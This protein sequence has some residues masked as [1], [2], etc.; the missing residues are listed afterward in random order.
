MDELKAKIFWQL[1][2]KCSNKVL[3]RIQ[4][5]F[6]FLP[7]PSALSSDQRS[8]LPESLLRILDSHLQQNAG[9]FV[10][11]LEYAYEYTRSQNLRLIELGGPD[12]PALLAQI[13]DAPALFYLLGS[14]ELV[15]Q[16][17]I[18]IVGSRRCSRGGQV[19]ARI[20]SRHLAEAGFTITSGLA[21]GI[22]TAAHQGALEVAMQN[23][24][25]ESRPN[26][27]LCPKDNA[28]NPLPC[29]SQAI[30][31]TTI[32]V[33]G[34][35]LDKI[36]P[37][38]NGALASQILE[39]GGALI[40]EFAPGV[41]PLP[42]HFPRRNRI[43]SGLSAASLIVEASERSGSLITARLALEQGREVLVLPGSIHDPLKSGCLRLI[44]E[45]ATLVSEPR[46][47]VAEISS[48][49]GFQLDLVPCERKQASNARVALNTDQ[50][51]ILAKIEFEPI[52]M[53]DLLQVTGKE[54]MTLM[55]I[56]LDLELEGL[57]QRGPTGIQRLR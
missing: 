12:Y 25:N 3:R 15:H 2:P 13:P 23:A 41:P 7:D 55:E 34:A 24:L 20:F 26:I 56:L 48:L 21:L 54:A 38:R 44:R 5:K 28:P 52:S 45:G 6:G 27:P 50:S 49:L 57:I 36:Y 46:Q 53:E 29:T 1:L 51:S 10:E 32:A 47:M 19:D 33:L 43:I 40:S 30:T 42:D 17:Q 16:P 4:Q 18:A 35:G 22:D 37:A 9:T 11:R 31:G 39:C 14:A 8:A